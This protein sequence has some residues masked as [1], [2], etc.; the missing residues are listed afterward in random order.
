M[1]HL[2]VILFVLGL[3]FRV[4]L[5]VLGLGFRVILFVWGEQGCY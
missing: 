2:E 1:R 5:F 3:G 4:I